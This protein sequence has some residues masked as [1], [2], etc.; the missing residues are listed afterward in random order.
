MLDFRVRSDRC[1]RCG[2]CVLDCPAR[3]IMLK[4]AFESVPELKRL[5]DLKPG[6]HYYAM[7][8]GPPLLYHSRTVQRDSAATVRRPELLSPG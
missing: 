5:L 7:L 4:L 8:F 1:D 6:H 2:L 3:I